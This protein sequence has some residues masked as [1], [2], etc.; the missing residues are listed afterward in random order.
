M[1]LISSFCTDQATE[2]EIIE[3]AK[4]ASAHEFITTFPDGYKTQVGERGVSL[5]GKIS[6]QQELIFSLVPNPLHPQA[7]KSKELLSQEH[8]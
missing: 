5:S 6:K 7:A 8:Y 1:R 3:A 4:Q 2:E